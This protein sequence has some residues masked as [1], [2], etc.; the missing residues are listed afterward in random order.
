MD[1]SLLQAR[2]VAILKAAVRIQYLYFSTSIGHP[3]L[4]AVTELDTLHEL[5]AICNTFQ[6]RVHTRLITLRSPLRSL[7][8]EETD[9]IADSI[10]ASFLHESLSHFA[11]TLEALNLNFFPLNI[12]PSSITT[13]FTEVRSLKFRTD[14]ED[15]DF[16]DFH[17]LAILLRLFPNLDDTLVLGPF[18]MELTDDALLTLRA[19]S[20]EEQTAHALSYRQGWG[21]LD[22]LFPLEMTAHRL[23]HVIVLVEFGVRYKW[24]AH[25]KRKR[26]SWN[27]LFDKVLDSV[28]HLPLTHLRV[29]LDCTVRQSVPNSYP[30]GHRVHAACEGETDLQPAAARLRDTMPT[31]ECLF[32][33]ARGR[34]YIVPMRDNWRVDTEETPQTWLSSKAWQ[35]IHDT[36]NEVTP[37]APGVKSRGPWAELSGEAAER[38][39]DREELRVS[40]P[41]KIS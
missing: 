21:V 32:L 3:V 9:P 15:I 19:Q 7:R 20:K 18:F 17:P 4:A 27:R 1:H 41:E 35:T 34:A 39:M 24:R 36:Y 30:C 14:N 5:H 10:T 6:S 16:F 33:E 28:K 25:L 26:V 11:P 31:L 8:I 23:T 12:S 37:L 2:L 13:Q 38:V 29:V 22:G 40:R